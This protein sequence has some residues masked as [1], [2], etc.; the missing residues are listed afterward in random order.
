MRPDLI[1]INTTTIDDDD[2][3]DLF[4]TW[5]HRGNGTFIKCLQL[6]SSELLPHL[7]L[8]VKIF[9]IKLYFQITFCYEQIEVEF[10]HHK[11]HLFKASSPTGMARQSMMADGNRFLSR[12]MEFGL[13]WK[14]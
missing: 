7:I 6:L 8:I 13:L 5:R 3:G 2:D 10:T 12:M 1:I 11:V 14:V 9:C 4:T